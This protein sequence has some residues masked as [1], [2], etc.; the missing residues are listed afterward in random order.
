MFELAR[1]IDDCR[2]AISEDATHKAVQEVVAR[3]VSDPESVMKALGEPK[4][5]AVQKL[6]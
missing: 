4:L 3:A 2:A 5:A 6:H 1:F